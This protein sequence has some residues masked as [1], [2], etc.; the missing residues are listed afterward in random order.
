MHSI[1]HLLRGQAKLDPIPA[2]ILGLVSG[3]IE[4]FNLFSFLRKR[5]LFILINHIGVIE[6]SFGERCAQTG[7]VRILNNP[8][9]IKR[10]RIVKQW[11]NLLL[12]LICTI[13]TL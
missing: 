7:H 1:F 4:I 6:V 8:A 5:R 10:F 2:P 9:G 3:Q 12:I 13:K 11:L